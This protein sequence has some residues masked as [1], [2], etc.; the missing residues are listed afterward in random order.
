G[1]RWRENRDCASTVQSDIVEGLQGATV[2]HELLPKLKELQ[3]KS[4]LGYDIQV[5]G[6]VEE[7]SKGQRSINAGVPVML[8]ITFTLLMLQL[9][10]FSRSMLVFITG[11][12]GI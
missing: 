6:A 7:S 12:L 1:M 10:S 11:P 5:A 3:R 4:P 8:F 9:H 2:T